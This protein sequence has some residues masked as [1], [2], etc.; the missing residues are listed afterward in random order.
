M[1]GYPTE[2]I[3]MTDVLHKAY[4][5]ILEATNWIYAKTLEEARVLAQQ[6]VDKLNSDT[7]AT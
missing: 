4:P 2:Q 7:A 1:R 5:D 3:L 6:Q